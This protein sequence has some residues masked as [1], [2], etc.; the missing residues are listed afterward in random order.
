MIDARTCSE[1]TMQTQFQIYYVSSPPTGDLFQQ[2]SDLKNP[3][4][5]KDSQQHLND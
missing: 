2:S 3:S 4:T 5:T 1:Q